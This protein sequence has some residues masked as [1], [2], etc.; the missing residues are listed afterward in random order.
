MMEMGAVFFDGLTFDHLSLPIPTKLLELYHVD[1]LF[2]PATFYLVCNKNVLNI[3]DF[4][5]SFLLFW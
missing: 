5:M 2:E 1:K 4:C 3:C